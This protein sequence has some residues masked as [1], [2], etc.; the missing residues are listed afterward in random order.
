MVFKF[1]G[2]LVDTNQREVNRLTQVV[3]KING[4]ADKAKKLAKKDFSQKTAEFKER[5]K[6]GESLDELLPEVY[7]VTREAAEQATGLRPFDEQLMAAIVFHQ[8]KIAEQ[9][10][11][12]GKTLSAVAALY[13]NA[14]AGRGCHLVTVNDYLARRDTGWMGP[15]YRLLGLSVGVVYAGRG[16]QPA[17]IYDPEYTDEAATDERLRYLKPVSRQEAYRADI[18][19]GTN[20]ELGFDY[21]RD[22]MVAALPQMVQRG[23][24]FAIVDE[25]DSI[26]VDEARTPLIIS[27][28]DTEPTDKY[29]K[30]A[31]LVNELSAATDY[32]SDEKHKTV[33][34]T[35][36]GIKKV[37][38]KLNVD[39][40]YEK[41]FDTIHHLEQ[42]LKARE[43]FKKD[44]DYVIKDGEIIIVDEFTGRLMFGRRYS[45]GLHQAIEAKENVTIKQ[46]SKTL[47]TISFQ[48]Y[49]RMYDKLA[50][51][52]GTAATE[53]EEFKKIYNLETVVI[54][55]HEPMVRS[56]HPDL[57]Y[58]TARAKY[59][60]IGREV[61]E[62]HQKGQP[63][64]IGT[65]SIDKNQIVAELLK[66]K[67]IPHQVLNAKN[68]EKE[69]QII[70]QAG[71]VGGVTVATNLAGRGVDIVLGGDSRE[72]ESK[73]IWQKQHDKVV[74][75]GG[76]HVIGVERHESRRI[77]NQLR[78]RSGR[79]GDPGSSRFYVSLEDD[80][81][82]IFGGEQISK[83]MTTFKMPEDVPLEHAMV[84]R[85]IEQA[86]V[87]VESFHFD[88]RKHLVEYDDVMNKQREIIYQRRKA[89]LT[90]FDDEK[91]RGKLKTRLGEILDQQIEQ[92]VNLRVNPQTQAIDYET[93]VKD[94]VMVVPFDP[95]SQKRITDQLEK[96][97]GQE[98]VAELVKGL[99]E[100]TY[101]QREKELG[102]GLMREIEKF[103]L[104]STIDK[105]WMDHLDAVDDLR[106][107]IGLRGYAQRDPL[108]EYKGEAFSMFEK[109]VATI[110]Y[111][112]ARRVFRVQ[113]GQRPTPPQA[114]RPMAETPP[115]PPQADASR[116]AG[117]SP[118][119]AGKHKLGRNDPC[120]CGS[121]KKWK[122]CHYPEL[123]AN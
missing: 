110:D 13:L 109:L 92:M 49:F 120:W 80:I 72:F 61:E 75:L 9:K 22:N 26:L 112:V 15:I 16:D 27:A 34:L 122:K 97:E 30:F 106:E 39:N 43:H 101:E 45:E 59:A 20:N 23:H 96:A 74:S 57:V 115:P 111:E 95:A 77:D 85:A 52:T 11:G 18:T 63:V 104:L 87:K 70:S 47:A 119:D 36:H 21:L 33:N 86:Q 113:V 67:K 35:E 10:T 99:V 116:R 44:R 17:E 40:L 48:N 24:K 2:K 98:K 121:G 79:Q 78:G 93:L 41:D 108:V 66:R 7:A 31:G 114:D 42:A 90:N 29:F 19:Y 64:L 32:E 76:L 6:K 118:A 68:H 14:L 100:R 83:L 88:A 12:E 102:E 69:A 3:G 51:M 82:R 107:G 55:T 56:D 73:K 84:S 28:P 94:L 103:V 4:L 91:T 5:L 117:P 123:P 105:L 62:R 50:G 60:A 8:G 1:L 65:S 25:V 46:E 71:K 81:M 58:K 37:E 89:I 53:A 54:P 38:K